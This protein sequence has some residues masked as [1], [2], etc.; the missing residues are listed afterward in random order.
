MIVAFTIDGRPQTKQ[1][2]RL[3]R[4]GMV[5][6]PEKTEAYELAVWYSAMAARATPGMFADVALYLQVRAVFARPKKASRPYPP[7][8]DVDNILKI[9]ADGLRPA[10]RDDVQFV[11]MMVTKEFGERERVDVWVGDQPIV[12]TL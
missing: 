12:V 3:G 9:V 11:S 10:F 4:N 2:P 5:Y 7:V 6:T 1:R 8:C